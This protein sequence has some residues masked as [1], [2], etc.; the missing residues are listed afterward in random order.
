MPKRILI[1]S[2]LSYCMSACS[3]RVY[4]PVEVREVITERQHIQQ[5]GG[6]LIR[7][8][9]SGDTLHSIAFESNL[10]IKNLVAWNNIANARDL[11]IG[12]RLRLTRPTNHVETKSSWLNGA[13]AGLDPVLKAEPMPPSPNGKKSKQAISSSVVSNSIS[14]DLPSASKWVWPVKGR[15]VRF[16]SPKDGQ[17]GVDIAVESG[18][19][20]RA[21]RPGE[22]VYAGSSLKGYGK[23]III[24]HDSEFISAYAHNRK[25]IVREGQQV[26]AGQEI[27][28]S[29]FNNMREQALQFQIRIDGNSVNPLPFLKG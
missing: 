27:G 4:A 24:K 28:I 1:V 13:G 2:L 29:G 11:K 14:N 15:V 6:H 10:S 3:P 21:S 7:F 25:I 16:F 9:K 20:V 17:Q 8:V 5:Y 22:I 19:S 18:T 12:Q 26:T 23:L